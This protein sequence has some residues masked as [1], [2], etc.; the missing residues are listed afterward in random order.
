[1]LAFKHLQIDTN[2]QPDSQSYSSEA[3]E[4]WKK[5]FFSA[6]KPPKV[7]KAFTEAPLSEGIN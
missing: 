1:M 2:Y 3:W 5:S 7:T 4:L 6:K